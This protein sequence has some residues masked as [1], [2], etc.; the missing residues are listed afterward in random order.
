MIELY[1]HSGSVNHG[2]EAIVRGTVKVLGNVDILW[3]SDINSDKKYG[4]NKLLI[5]NQQV[6]KFL[7]IVF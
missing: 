7:E 3:S 6:K 2:C 4:L 5:L 1:G